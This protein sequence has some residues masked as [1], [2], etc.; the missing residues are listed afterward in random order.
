MGNVS[1][2]TSSTLA[3]APLTDPIQ[4]ALRILISVTRNVD[5]LASLTEKVVATEICESIMA[6]MS[7]YIALQKR[8]HCQGLDVVLTLVKDMETLDFIVSKNV[9]GSSADHKCV[10]GKSL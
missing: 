6:L 8:L 9:L 2:E 7:F 5:K 4:E 10:A 3:S 1:L